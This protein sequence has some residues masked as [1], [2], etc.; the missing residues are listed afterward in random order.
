[1]DLSIE[2]GMPYLNISSFDIRQFL[3]GIAEWNE[4][5]RRALEPPCLNMAKVG[6]R[7]VFTHT[8]QLTKGCSLI[9]CTVTVYE[10]CG[11]FDSHHPQ[12][13]LI[14]TTDC[15]DSCEQ[16]LIHPRPFH[17]F[18]LVVYFESFK[19]SAIILQDLQGIPRTKTTTA[20]FFTGAALPCERQGG[21]Q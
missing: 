7:P 21:W 11:A 3:F 19:V 6:A 17:C 5:S 4:P 8:L 12:E 16:C 10:R 9:S 15:Q 2:V 18:W 14:K 20:I 13:Q 1:M